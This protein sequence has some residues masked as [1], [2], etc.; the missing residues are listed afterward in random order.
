MW[1]ESAGLCPFHF[2]PDC[3]NARGIHGIMYQGMLFD[4]FPKFVSVKGVIYD[5]VQSCPHLRPVPITDCLN[6]QLPERLVVKGEFAQNIEHFA[7]KGF[8]FL[9]QFL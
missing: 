3:L 7:A 6:E 8:T 9:I 1:L 2:L 4:E 5:F